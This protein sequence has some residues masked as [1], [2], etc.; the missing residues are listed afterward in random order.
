MADPSYEAFIAKQKERPAG[1]GVPGSYEEFMARTQARR[2]PV[3]MALTGAANEADPLLADSK[4]FDSVRAGFTRSV[5]SADRYGA[6]LAGLLNSG[7]DKLAALTGLDKGGA[8]Q[9]L[10]E[11]YDARSAGLLKHAEEIMPSASPHLADK[12]G[13]LIG[14][15]PVSLLTGAAAIKTGGPVLGLA[16]LEALSV[17]DKDLLTIGKHAVTG[18]ALGKL[19]QVSQ[20]FG[21][22][23]RVALMGGVSTGASLVSGDPLEDALLA[24]ATSGALALNPRDFLKLTRRHRSMV[25]Q[26]DDYLGDKVDDLGGMVFQWQAGRNAK[27]RANPNLTSVQRR[28]LLEDAVS[29]LDTEGKRLKFLADTKAAFAKGEI[30]GSDQLLELWVNSLLSGP[31]T[32]AVNGM[33]N[34]A[35]A[36]WDIPRAYTAATIGAAK[37]GGRAVVDTARRVAGRQPV[38]RA[39]VKDLFSRYRAAGSDRVTFREANAR[40]AGLVTGM[41]EGLTAFGKVMASEFPGDVTSKIEL[42]RQR[43]LPGLSGQVA[44]TGG[45]VLMATDELFKVI[46]MRA[47]INGLAVRQAHMERLSGRAAHARAAELRLRPSKQMRELALQDARVN[48]FTNELQSGS[49]LAYLQ[50]FG[51]THPLA[52]VLV[53]FFRTPTQIF[54]LAGRHVPVLGT[55][56]SEAKKELAA[57][58][59]RRDMELARQTLSAAVAGTVATMAAEGLITGSGPADPEIRRAWLTS[60]RRPFSF[61]FGG[62]QVSYARI[63]PLASVVGPIA[64]MVDIAGHLKPD[65]RDELGALLVASLRRN[66]ENKT[67]ISGL[68]GALAAI[69]DPER[70]GASWVQRMSASV[71]PSAFAQATRLQDPILRRADSIRERVMSRTPG[72]SERLLPRRNTWGE[73]VQLDR[74]F[75]FPMSPLFSNRLH[76]DKATE[77]VLRVGARLVAPT[78]RFRGIQLDP[79]EHDLLLKLVG[80]TAKLAV[81]ELVNTQ[82]WKQLEK[83]PTLQKKLLER[84][85][86]DVKEAAGDQLV[87]QLFRGNDPRVTQ[88]DKVRDKLKIFRE[89]T[90]AVEQEQMDN[91]P[92][93]MKRVMG[94]E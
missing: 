54:R 47:T 24:G 65:E 76:P 63:E 55:L 69:D 3:E 6:R 80:Q 72:Y 84:V 79:T 38:H 29:L 64:D 77:E 27:A 13:N 35:T 66:V 39:A 28:A 15:L 21:P 45:R 50:Q 90:G 32:W 68:T 75:G 67:F 59:G 53:P 41:R 33:S 48:T 12:I 34:A 78:D 30:K 8:F 82:Q 26:I 58:G 92:S 17:A 46:N 60:G 31:Q 36:L 88:L 73:A 37:A 86:G 51:E 20:A 93:L 42:P 9:Q 49:I 19:M 5:A 83:S 2:S 10:E 1:P 62:E 4:F 23:S 57:G 40:V 43:T 70:F 74:G 91:P 22:V 25:G 56:V 94:L 85:Y 7:A 61:N 14:N 87:L 44:R 16:G 11:F 18:A 52:K 89:L 71:V 81:D